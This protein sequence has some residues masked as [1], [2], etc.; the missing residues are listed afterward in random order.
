MC[1]GKVN[2]S[3]LESIGLWEF[4]IRVYANAEVEKQCLQLQ[5]ERDLDVNLLLTCCWYGLSGRGELPPETIHTVRH[6]LES[7]QSRVVQ[8]LRQVRRTLKPVC[9]TDSRLAA[10][11]RQVQRLELLA[12]QTEQFYLENRLREKSSRVPPDGSQRYSD[13]LANLHNYAADVL[14]DPLH[15]NQTQLRCLLDSIVASGIA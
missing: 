8:P 5:D 15:F 3:P 10:L 2:F 6:E 4:S 1:S 12:E 7:W 9:I 14:G 11:Y 13:A